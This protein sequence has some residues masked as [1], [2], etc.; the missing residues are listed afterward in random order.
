VLYGSAV[1]GDSSDLMRALR[2]PVLLAVVVVVLAALAWLFSGGG[3]VQFAR[4]ASA[5]AAKPAPAAPVAAKEATADPGERRELVPVAA[6][7][8]PSG[9]PAPDVVFVGRCVAAEDGAPL[10]EV[11]VTYAPASTLELQAALAQLAG[12]RTD[13]PQTVA[14]RSDRDGRFEMAAW[15]ARSWLQVLSFQAADRVRVEGS[16]GSARGQV[17]LGDIAMKAGVTPLARVVDADGAPQAGLQVSLLRSADWI[18]GFLTAQAYVDVRSQADGSLAL[19][20]PLLPGRWDVVCR[21]REV[22]GPKQW[23]V[24]PGAPR[25]D[26]VVNVNP[27]SISGV[28]VDLQGLPLADVIVEPANRGEY[29]GAMPRSDAEGRF[30]VRRWSTDRPEPHRLW[31]TK[32]GYRSLCSELT[33]WGKADLRFEL[34]PMREL[35]LLAVDDASGAPVETFGVRILH[36]NGVKTD[37]RSTSGTLTEVGRHDGGRVHIPLDDGQHRIFVQPGGKT[38]CVGG[39]F[40]VMASEAMPRQVVVRLAP[41][42]PRTV[43]VITAAGTGIEGSKVEL[44]RPGAPRPVVLD[45]ENQQ[46]VWNEPADHQKTPQTMRI[47]RQRTDHDGEAALTLPARETLDLQVTGPSHCPFSRTVVF[48]DEQEPLVIVVAVGA[49]V[50]GTIEPHDYVAR[51]RS[52]AAG[53]GTPA[54]A[55]QLAQK[56]GHE[57]CWFPDKPVPLTAGG[58][59][60]LEHIPPGTWEVVTV[61]WARHS[62]VLLPLGS[63]GPLVEG[64]TT[65]LKIDASAGM[66]CTLQG[67]VLVNGEPWVAKPV[68]VRF[69]YGVSLLREYPGSIG[70]GLT[71]NADGVFTLDRLPGRYRVAV[72][73][74]DAPE[75]AQMAPGATAEFTFT[76]SSGTI[77]L[78]FVDE[79]GAP[80][81]G[82]CGIVFGSDDAQQ[83]VTADAA[84]KVELHR[85]PGPIRAGVMPASLREGE[86]RW[87]Y[88]KEHGN[89]PQ[90]LRSEALGT[91]DVQ[92]MPSRE[93]ALRITVPASAG[94]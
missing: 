52:L 28:V 87:K 50:S 18:K 5:D 81:P 17:D 85:A 49:A 94:Y 32:P 7:A 16:N 78:T 53:A 9:R 70:W 19:P 48:A 25:F 39:P 64:Q 76:I 4:N 43:R 14:T 30:I 66:P 24:S 21:D 6:E 27:E 69:E 90:S 83:E 92:L 57:L 84:C 35:E 26:I 88:R 29:W 68:S 60:H 10:A 20:A 40:D 2:R 73:G 1:P 46:W 36:S 37:W 65:E 11:A 8:S 55:I 38:H 45:P 82:A 44:L 41:L 13:P 56:R 79:H 93:L 59:F 33:P 58:A 67:R 34:T 23:D 15:Q 12:E 86:A 61:A 91:V 77:A 80:V 54:P 51:V 74:V 22:I 71:T 89:S 3:G 42:V 72:D 63:T 47:A 31:F 62:Q 75:V